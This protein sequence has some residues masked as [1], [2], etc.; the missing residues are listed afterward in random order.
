MF[1][2][3]QDRDT[4]GQGFTHHVGDAVRI[5]SAHIGSILNEVHFSSDCPPWT[6]GMSQ[7]MRYLSA[8]GLI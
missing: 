4:P 5:S 8:Q 3:S 1:A 7:Q 2:P 6:W